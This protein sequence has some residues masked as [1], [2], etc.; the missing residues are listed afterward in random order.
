MK[1]GELPED[2]P[3][4]Q[5][6]IERSKVR[7]FHQR[8]QSAAETIK[9]PQA[10]HL[11]ELDASHGVDAESSARNLDD[12]FLTAPKH[13]AAQITKQFTESRRAVQ[14]ETG[15]DK[16]RITLWQADLFTCSPGDSQER[17]HFQ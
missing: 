17:D 9:R 12:K 10:H 11:L 1:R 2:F 5:V 4:F 15:A 6:N 16:L 7:R 13:L 3:Q 8:F 14:Y